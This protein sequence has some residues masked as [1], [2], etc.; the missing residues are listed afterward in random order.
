MNIPTYIWTWTWLFPFL[1]NT[2]WNINKSLRFAGILFPQLIAPYFFLFYSYWPW[3]WTLIMINIILGLLSQKFFQ[4]DACSA[5]KP[6]SEEDR[7]STVNFNVQ[8]GLWLW[9]WVI[10]QDSKLGFPDGICIAGSIDLGAIFIIR[11]NPP[12][13]KPLELPQWR[14]TPETPSWY[15]AD[16]NPKFPHN[17]ILFN[18]MRWKRE[19]VVLSDICLPSER[20]SFPVVE[21]GKMERGRRSC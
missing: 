2:N 7:L 9:L 13:S 10:D 12:N 8:C 14:R 21:M 11:I 17:T 18:L 19:M 16:F 4:D 15:Q 20:K 6:F 3:S 1:R 5:L